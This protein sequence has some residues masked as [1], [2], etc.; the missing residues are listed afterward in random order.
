MIFGLT[1]NE[2]KELE[3][4]YLKE[5]YNKEKRRFCFIPH[6]LNNGQ[7]VWLQF[8]YRRINYIKQNYIN[9][10]YFIS[11]YVDKYGDCYIK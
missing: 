1:Y 8:V 11:I 3:Q 9:N 2:I 6:R 5:N 10:Y 4:E 7:W